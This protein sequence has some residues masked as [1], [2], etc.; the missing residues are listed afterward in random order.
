MACD[1]NYLFENERL[2]N[3]ISSHVHCKSG[4]MSETVEVGVFVATDHPLIGSDI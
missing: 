1:H 2:L 4:N 3:V